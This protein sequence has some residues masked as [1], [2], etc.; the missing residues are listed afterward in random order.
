MCIMCMILQISKRM[1]LHIMYMCMQW[2]ERQPNKREMPG[3]DY[4]CKQVHVLVCNAMMLFQTDIYIHTCMQMHDCDLHTCQSNRQ[5][6]YSMQWAPTKQEKCQVPNDTTSVFLLSS[7]EYMGTTKSPKQR[8]GLSILIDR[9]SVPSH[10]ADQI[11]FQEKTSMC[12][13][14]AAHSILYSRAL[15]YLRALTETLHHFPNFG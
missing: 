7:S 6:L 8:S 2:D 13:Y 3:G 14:V 5:Q 10:P 1:L 9:K 11:S 15:K 12:M 4:V